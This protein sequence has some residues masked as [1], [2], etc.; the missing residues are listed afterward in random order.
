MLLSVLTCALQTYWRSVT[1]LRFPAK[2]RLVS[3][4]PCHNQN[5][6]HRPGLPHAGD[7]GEELKDVTFD[8][9]P[10]MSTYLLAYIVGEF[11]SIED[12]TQEG[13]QVRVFTTPGLKEEVGIP[14]APPAEQVSYRQAQCLIQ[15]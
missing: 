2:R 10:I 12:K 9:T 5:L 4:P 14:A 1:C 11:E 3:S 8:T 6:I 7:V 13:I 15:T